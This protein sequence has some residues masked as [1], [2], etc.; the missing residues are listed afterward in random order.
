MAGKINTTNP[1]PMISEALEY[2]RQLG[3][4]ARQYASQSG[5]IKAEYDNIES[6]MSSIIE[7]MKSKNKSDQKRYEELFNSLKEAHSRE[8]EKYYQ[9]KTMIDSSLDQITDTD[10][11]KDIDKL[12]QTLMRAKTAAENVKMSE[13]IAKKWEEIE[14]AATTP[15][16]K[17]AANA[18]KTKAEGD[19]ARYENLVNRLK[20]EAGSIIDEYGSSGITAK[21]HEIDDDITKLRDKLRVLNDNLLVPGITPEKIEKIEKEI[22]ETVVN[23][24]QFCT[25]EYSKTAQIL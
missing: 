8:L 12:R 6:I 14:A 4:I 9:I 1:S 5:E 25:F 23:C 3:E 10:F 7:G 11:K 15:S 20:A 24:F 19:K 17:A 16:E 2:Q 21:A 22:K 13:E 18:E